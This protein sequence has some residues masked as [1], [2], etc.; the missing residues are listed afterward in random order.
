MALKKAEI[1]KYRKQLEALRGQLTNTLKGSSAEVKT[2][3]ES[4]GYSQ[5][6]ADQGRTISI[7]P[8]ASKYLPKSTISCARLS[9]RLK[10]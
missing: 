9:G 3:D 2:T 7:G 10:R 6:Q 5:H 4:A 1:D 8:S